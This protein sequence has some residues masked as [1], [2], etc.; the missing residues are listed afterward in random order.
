MSP[1]P[2]PFRMTGGR[3]R[4]DGQEVLRGVDL[5]V[6]PGE[7]LALLGANGSGKSTLIR[8]LLGLVPLAG[9]STEIYGV[10]PSRFRDWRR[11]GYVPQRLTVGGGVPATV[12]EVVSSGRIARRSRL[13]P[14]STAADKEAVRR[15]L[16][17]VGLTD[18]ASHPAQRLSGGQQQR[19]LIARALAGEPDTFVMDEPTAGVD[20]A[21]QAALAET[22][23]TLVAQGR[24]IVLVAH[25]LGPLEP[26]ISR[27]VVLE[28]GRV[29][30]VGAPPPP[31]GDCA[32]PGHQH[33][34][35]HAPEAAPTPLTTW[36]P[37]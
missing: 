5:R 13:R 16:E 7:V 19:V 21:S 11:I 25:E 15:A 8:A 33:L 32:K 31:E 17:S 29:A 37:A 20:T 14:F 1:T 35:P 28:T 26:L 23:H 34:H 24:T 2:A 36:N 27:A 12:R 10:P 30:H 6:E 22:L 18:R 3:V 4:L 9:G